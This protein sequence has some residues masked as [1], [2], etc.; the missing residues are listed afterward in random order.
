[1]T[2]TKDYQT[3]QREAILRCFE[4][5][6]RRGMTA[7][8]VAQHLQEKGQAVGRTTIYRTIA[9][10]LEQGLLI[11][12]N[13]GSAS[14]LR[15]QHRGQTRHI[16]V[17]CSGCGLIAALTCSAVSDFERH[18]ARDHGFRLQE[19]ECLLPGLCAACQPKEPMAP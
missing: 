14:P 7:A 12:L 15:Y 16:S 11:S 9:R 13:E 10:L 5:Q 2:Q 17:R 6:P 18:L 19:E 8:E 4:S 3:R 1:M